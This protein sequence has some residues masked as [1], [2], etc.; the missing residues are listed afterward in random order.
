MLAEVAPGMVG[1]ETTSLR[2]EIAE[3]VME[4]DTAWL[5]KKSIGLNIL[6]RTC[7]G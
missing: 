2:R 1:W 5:F 7:I 3:L 6:A 4:P